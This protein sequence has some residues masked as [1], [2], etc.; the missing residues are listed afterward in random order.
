MARVTEI[1]LP[2]TR[3]AGD[4]FRRVLDQQSAGDEDRDA[5][6]KAEHEVHIVLDQDDRDLARQRSDR[7]EELAAFD[8]RHAGGWL[9]EQQYPGLIGVRQ[10]NLHQP[11]LYI[12]R[13]IPD[14]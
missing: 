6:R 12:L 7:L 11:L 10:R 4:S 5:V 8:P 14:L 3:V 13:V 9:V 1:E 2:H